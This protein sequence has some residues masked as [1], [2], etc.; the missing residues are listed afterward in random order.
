MGRTHRSGNGSDQEFY[1]R[2]VHA[3]FG[4]PESDFGLRCRC[5]ERQ[6]ILPLQTTA[7]IG[8]AKFPAKRGRSAN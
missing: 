5:D 6:T 1:P 3:R 8:Y 4:F 7:E 2:H